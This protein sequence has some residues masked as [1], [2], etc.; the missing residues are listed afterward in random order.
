M[1]AQ[2]SPMSDP[3][4][5]AHEKG[6]ISYFPTGGGSYVGPLEGYFQGIPLRLESARLQA[7]AQQ[8]ELNTRLEAYRNFHQAFEATRLRGGKVDQYEF[9]RQEA[10]DYLDEMFPTTPL[11][12]RYVE[13]LW[14]RFLRWLVR[15][16]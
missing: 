9:D 8:Q 15:V 13:P 3:A 4:R 12:P 7:E 11:G 14:I 6:R 1:A 10:A 2:A 5:D 16:I